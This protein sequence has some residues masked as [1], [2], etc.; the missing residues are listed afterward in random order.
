M[1]IA[2]RQIC[3]LDLP[4]KPLVPVFFAHQKTAVLTPR[5]LLWNQK[6]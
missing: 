2:L 5:L 4:I 1:K 6:V 3:S